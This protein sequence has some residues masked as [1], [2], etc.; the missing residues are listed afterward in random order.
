MNEHWVWAAGIIFHETEHGRYTL[1]SF[2]EVD[3]WKYQLVWE[4]II[5]VVVFNAGV[6]ISQSPKNCHQEILFVGDYYECKDYAGQHK[7]M[8][9]LEHG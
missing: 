3:T 8:T 4:P 7:V 9:K 1:K 6:Q 2:K 5:K